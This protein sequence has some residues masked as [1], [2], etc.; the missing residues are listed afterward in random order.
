MGLN[1]WKLD[2]EGELTEIAEGHLRAW[3]Q[4][5]AAQHARLQSFERIEAEVALETAEHVHYSDA[6][7]QANVTLLQQLAALRA[8]L[9][10]ARN[11]ATLQSTRCEEELTRRNLVEMELQSCKAK[12]HTYK[13]QTDEDAGLLEGHYEEK[14][15]ALETE[16]AAE[17]KSLADL[18]ARFEDEIHRRETVEQ[19]LHEL[20]AFNARKEPPIDEMYYK[21]QIADLHADVGIL[22]QDLIA[23]TARCKAEEAKALLAILPNRT[24]RSE[25][26]RLRE[27]I[28]QLELEKAQTA[29]RND[30]NT[31]R[32]QAMLATEK[33]KNH[34]L[35]CDVKFL[36][37]SRSKAGEEIENYKT[38][39]VRLETRLSAFEKAHRSARRV[40]D[41]TADED[42]PCAA[43]TMI[44]KASR[45]RVPADEIWRPNSPVA[46]DAVME[47]N[48]RT[49]F[50][51]AIAKT[52]VTVRKQAS[53]PNF[54]PHLPHKQGSESPANGPDKATA[55]QQ[56]SKAAQSNDAEGR[57]SGATRKSASSTGL[58]IT[59]SPTGPRPPILHRESSRS[60]L[61]GVDRALLEKL[62]SI[63]KELDLH[64]PI[65]EV[66]DQRGKIARVYE[67]NEIF[68]LSG[69]PNGAVKIEY[70]AHLPHTKKVVMSNGD[71]HT[72]SADGIERITHQA[73]GRKETRHPRG[74][75]VTEFC[76][77]QKETE[78]PDG[79]LEIVYP[80]GLRE[81]KAVKGDGPLYM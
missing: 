42:L 23:M 48:S 9:V 3:Q 29:K 45:V 30:A 11:E 71:I 22:Q 21:R 33:L 5:E 16:L 76:N 38:K 7:E 47:G 55:S 67:H 62:D 4:A 36:E 54:K 31:S 70:H 63:A 73:D 19:K 72:F 56:T 64:T 66:I 75:I 24:E 10:A 58:H 43:Q 50:K 17:R 74:P 53:T 51:P 49:A 26:Q 8:E 57:P 12:I 28:E 46:A 68:S 41:T 78:W 65:K 15:A 40:S 20:N 81:V 69:Y 13:Q 44:A 32:V 77:G 61:S 59:K 60:K 1:V 34:D 37:L 52:K 79:R 80:N 27:K 39:I 35:A 14:I 2:V 25:V 18:N 6:G